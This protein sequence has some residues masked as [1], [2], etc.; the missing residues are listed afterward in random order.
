MEGL[1]RK[2]ALPEP[3]QINPAD[4]SADEQREKGIRQLSSSLQEAIDQLAKSTFVKNALGDPLYECYLAVKKFDWESYGS[5]TL[6]DMVEDLR[7]RYA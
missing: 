2:L 6:E 3:V 1:E 4:L 7:W 5:M